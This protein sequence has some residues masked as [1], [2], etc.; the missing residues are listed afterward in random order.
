M[1]M[2]ENWRSWGTTDENSSFLGVTHPIFGVSA[3]PG[4]WRHVGLR[5]SSVQGPSDASMNLSFESLSSHRLV[6]SSS[7]AP[8]IP[9][10]P[11]V[12]HPSGGALLALAVWVVQD[13]PQMYLCS[14]PRGPSWGSWQG[15]W[16]GRLPQKCGGV[17]GSTNVRLLRD[18][19]ATMW[20][21]CCVFTSHCSCTGA[22]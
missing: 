15:L 20:A 13:G 1:S 3:A 17:G 4:S 18:F 9:R 16:Q 10:I 5:D 19:A 8:G 21:E 11:V 12:P 14:R 6:F 22:L 2:H 7:V